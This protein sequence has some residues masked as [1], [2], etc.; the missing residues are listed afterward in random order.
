MSSQQ[1]GT[2]ASEADIQPGDVVIFRNH[3]E[4]PGYNAF[5][6]CIVE[7]ID[8]EGIVHLARPMM[9]TDSTGTAWMHAERFTCYTTSMLKDA[10]Y[11]T[12]GPRKIKDRRYNA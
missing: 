12:S 6:T 7:R 11:Y 4:S 2:Y 8:N 1:F 9:R 5:A 3:I 10:L